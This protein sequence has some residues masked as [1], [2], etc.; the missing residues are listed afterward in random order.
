MRRLHPAL[1]SLLGTLIAC[2]SG[3][4]GPAPADTY[5]SS[6]PDGTE[7][8]TVAD[9][10]PRD[11]PEIKD[12]TS[13]EV[14][15]GD[16]ADANEVRDTG[17]QDTT[18]VVQRWRSLLYPERWYPGLRTRSGAALQD[19]SY[20]GY[21]NSNGPLGSGLGKDGR[22]SL[23]RFDVTDFGAVGATDPESAVDNT[24]AFRDAI[25]AAEA[26]GGGL[27]Y[28][29]P[30]LYRI[31]LWLEIDASR[32]VLQ[33][34][35]P[36]QSRLWF[37]RARGMSHSAH[38]RV[39]GAADIGRP[40]PL[41]LDAQ[42]FDDAIQVDNSAGFHVG[43]DIAIGHEITAGFLDAHGMR[44][45]WGGLLGSWQPR[46][47]RTIVGIDRSRSPHKIM[48]DVP[49]RSELRVA[50]G[51]SVGR[52]S[53]IVREVGIE[54]LGIA[55]AT[56]WDYAWA[57]DKVAAIRMYGVAD[58]WVS[59]V[60]SF[61][62]PGAPESGM[63]AGAHLQ[64]EGIVIAR[65]KRVTVADTHMALAQNRGYGGNGYLY[66]LAQAN[67]VLIR[68]SSAQG[69]R[70]N[71]V[72]TSGLGTSGCVWLRVT[73]SD[74]AQVPLGP[75]TDQKIAARSELHTLGT[76][77]LVDSS[78]FHDGIDAL[79]RQGTLV[80]AAGQ[81]ATECVF[82]NLSSDELISLQYGVGYVIGTVKRTPVAT[83]LLLAGST[84]TEPE[85]WVEG[86]GRG[87]TL[88]PSS[89]YEDQLAR[90]LEGL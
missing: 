36:E 84:H 27:V 87:E 58:A 18:P 45:A 63:G 55:N 49:L 28:V 85:D 31:D 4:E 54:N 47:F 5:A 68:D 80:D 44:E 78:V 41:T 9:T 75:L 57:E 21:R 8:V 15:F 62:S 29:P 65:S 48:L 59:N 16:V 77:N 10:E 12:T 66:E 50:D 25:E 43:E 24:A 30:G 83:S 3:L 1:C 40:A 42:R 61:A 26:V 81:G 11:V 37:T 67:E 69:G 51:A 88:T 38:I 60:S 32:I 71:F 35:G 89:L 86:V 34:A 70:N 73:S 23:P 22:A 14:L 7:E 46:A 33:G 13:P 56:S 39:S 79:N 82:W 90:R 52:M 53:G 64:S 2:G 20:A 74:G 19:Y 72:I 76:A 6:S 17:P